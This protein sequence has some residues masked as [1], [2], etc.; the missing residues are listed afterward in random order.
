MS[1]GTGPILVFRY[2]PL[3]GISADPR[4]ATVVHR[5]QTLSDALRFCRA[6]ERPHYKH[7][8]LWIAREGQKAHGRRPAG[9]GP[10]AILRA[11]HRLLRENAELK[12][13]LR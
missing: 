2:G 3:S 9:Q 6:P 13:R 10:K 11:Y 12:A 8:R 5:A 7:T 1:Q 4:L